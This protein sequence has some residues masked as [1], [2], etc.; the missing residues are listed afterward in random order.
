[1]TKLRLTLLAGSASLALLHGNPAA[2]WQFQFTPD[3]YRVM[4]R[5]CGA[6]GQGLPC[7]YDQNGEGQIVGLT[8]NT[9]GEL[10]RRIGGTWY[11]LLAQNIGFSTGFNFFYTSPDCT[12]TAYLQTGSGQVV[13][14]VLVE[15]LTFFAQVANQKIWAPAG[16]PAQIELGSEAP[17]PPPVGS[18]KCAS[19]GGPGP[20]VNARPAVAVDTTVFTPDFVI[21]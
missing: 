16:T 19:F 1:M 2:A 18:G 8:A 10:Q 21:R 11:T 20:T 14:G 13:D 3:D 17:T 9:A 4:L 5:I 6:L 15:D 7:A 12:G